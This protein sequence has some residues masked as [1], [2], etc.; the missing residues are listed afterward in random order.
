M[1]FKSTPANSWPGMLKLFLTMKI[2][3]AIMM[4]S[5]LQ[6][7]AKSVAQ[8]ISIHEKNISL[9]KALTLIEK[10]SGYHFIYDSKLEKL[11]STTVSV[12][13]S[14]G[15]VTEVLDQCLE[16]LPI[17]YT[18]E[19]QT[20]ALKVTATPPVPPADQPIDQTITG[21]ITDESGLPLPGA[22]IML[23][24]T[25]VGAAADQE[26]KYTVRVPNGNVVL[27]FSSLGYNS[28]EV[29]VNGRNI[30]NVSLTIKAS[31]LNDVV[32]VGYGTQKKGTINGA[33]NTVGAKDIGDK[34]VLDPY[35]A[36]QGE[37]PNLI[38]QQP[39]L[40][41]G[42]N[43]NVN[44]RGIATTGNNNP[45][46]V[47]DGIVSQNINDLNLI[48]P[49][50]IASVTI[51]KDA[52]SAA[53]YGSRGANGVI[54][55]TTKSGKLNQKPT[56]TYNGSYGLQVPD[57]LVHKVSA[58]DNA[59]YRN[60]A[61]E[62]SGLPPSYTPEQIQQL[63]A[64]GNGTWDIQHLLYNAPLETDNVSVSG[65][66]PTNSYFISG[67]YENQMSNFIG[68]GG[69]GANFGFQKYNLRMN[70]TSVVG[71]F[72][73]NMILD[74]TKSRNKTNTVGDNNII[75]DAN[76]VPANYS[77]TNAQ[78]QYLTNP[79]ASQYNEYGVLEEGGWD[80]ADNDHIFA[81]LNGTL[82]I[83]KNLK[84]T[85]VFGVTI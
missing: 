27:V 43:V 67:G 61:L 50:D 57:V 64:Q 1:K 85:G 31:N 6:A 58:A 19:Q 18:I 65:G 45:L 13:V 42:A 8:V 74:Y 70:Q 54:L 22:T 80:Q 7:G 26:G 28:T 78:G 40:D 9:D 37:S 76:R 11:K 51:L 32:V 34:P 21:T 30:I 25:N 71:D 17:T 81:N 12:D 23:K 4:I 3:L 44:I 38:I 10:E 56:L 47:V 69:A 16:S 15:S 46:L 62:N 36:L 83:T 66:G 79:V 24:G 84:L 2:V 33:L 49:N 68:D 77:W 20:I 14:K 48:N 39:A 72:K 75:A 82:S 52:G 53:I 59:Y 55:I 35:Q 63:Q 29:A 5:V 73:L 60:M 41:P